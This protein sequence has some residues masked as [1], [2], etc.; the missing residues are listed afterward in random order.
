MSFMSFIK[1]SKH[2]LKFLHSILFC[3]TLKFESSTSFSKELF[4]LPTKFEMT[5]V[6]ACY[7]QV[8]FINK[9]FQ[10]CSG[11]KVLRIIS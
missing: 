2:V 11:D 7:I 10:V 4:N 3:F 8:G 1:L 5:I 6:R 9:G